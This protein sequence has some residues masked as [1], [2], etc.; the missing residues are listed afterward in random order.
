TA[1]GSVT[2]LPR[3]HAN[4]AGHCDLLEGSHDSKSKKELPPG[5]CSCAR[6]GGTDNSRQRNWRM[7]RL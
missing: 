5:H 7:A 1:F 4:P 3:L 2:E 6:R